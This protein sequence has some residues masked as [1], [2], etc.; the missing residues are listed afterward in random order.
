MNSPLTTQRQREL[1]EQISKL[2]AVRAAGEIEI[3]ARQEARIEKATADYNETR[4]RAMREFEI[5][6][7]KLTTTMRESRE[8]VYVRYESEGFTLGQQERQ[9]RA[10]ATRREATAIENAEYLNQQ[11]QKK[12]LL[13]FEE[14]DKGSKTEYGQFREQIEVRVAEI[15]TLV[16]EARKV[17]ERQGPWPAGEL[18][19]PPASRD[20]PK[21]QLL[22]DA[23]ADYQ[24]ARAC[25]IRLNQA[26]AAR[27]I[28]DGWPFL[29]SIPGALAGF[30][31]AWFLLP[32]SP[33]VIGG[34]V[35]GA[36]AVTGFGV[37]AI[38]KP[39]ARS[40]TLRGVPAFRQQVALAMAKITAAKQSAK[41]ESKLSRAKASVQRDNEIAGATE[42]LETI[43][44]Q[45]AEKREE[46]IAKATTELIQRRRVLEDSCERQLN[47]I[48][49]KSPQQ[50][51]TLE[52]EFRNYYADLYKR[53]MARRAA[54]RAAFENEWNALASQWAEGVAA[55]EKEIGEMQQV[56][57]ATFPKWNDV[58]P[59]HIPLVNEKPRPEGGP[60]DLPAL[61]FGRYEFRLDQLAGGIPTAHGLQMP[62][63]SFAIPAVVSYPEAPSLLFESAEEGRD[64]ASRAIQNVMLRLLTAFPPGK[65]RFTII[66]PVGLGKNFSAFMHLADYDEK[67]V[68]NRI[69]TE[70]SH[71]NQRLADLTEHMENVI[72]K[73]LR[74][75]FASI[76]EYNRSAGEV[77][78][79]FHI[80]VI[81][82]FP[83]NFSDE[84]ARRLVSIA[85]SGARC[86][87]YTLIGVDTKHRVPRNFELSE[88]EA[89]ATTLVWNAELDRFEWKD[90]VLKDL[91]LVCESPP[92]DNKVTEIIRA[93]GKQAK[94]ASRVE[95]PF[96]TVTPTPDNWWTLDSR[97]GIEVPLGRA[98]A[99]KLQYMRLGSGT[100]Q[101]VLI[102]GKTGSGKSTL[103]NAMI[104]NLALYY[105]PNE[106]QFFLI[107][108]KKGVEF[109]AYA[110]HGLPHARVI[111]I[112]SER[113]FGLSVL[114]RLDV[115]L[116]RRGDMFR[117]VGAQDVKGYRAAV[118]DADLPRMML[119]IDE[120]QEFF[121]S[122]DK[123]SHEASLLLD[124]LI[125]QGRAF[126]V[127]VLLGSQTLAGAYSLARATIGQMAVRIALQC[128]ESDAHLILSE[129]N[130]AARLLNRPGEAIY[131]DANGMF[132]GNHPFQIVWL[133]DHQREDYLHRVAEK[134]MAQNIALPPPTVFEGNAAA[135]PAENHLLREAMTSVP[136]ANARL[137]PRM[138][139]GSAVAIKDPPEMIFRRQ[140]GANLL[141][142]GQQEE[143][144][145]GILANAIIALD[146]QTS[147]ESADHANG[148][149]KNGSGDHSLA[150]FTILDGVRPDAAEAGFWQK[151]VSAV[152]PSCKRVS[153]RDA[154]AAVNA[155]A[156]EVDRRLAAGDVSSEP[157]FLI[158]HNLTRFRD[159]K[160]G[161]EMSFGSFD[162]DDAA[163]DAGKRLAT[164][165]REGPALGVHTLSWVD[166]Y[167]NLTRWVERATIR[168]FETR[169]LFQMSNND[170][171]N[172][173]D[174]PAAAKL[175]AHFAL[176][177]SEEQGQAEKFRPYGLPSDAWLEW[178]AEQRSSTGA[179]AGKRAAKKT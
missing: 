139:L 87:V 30:A 81:A 69:W 38:A 34:A 10:E 112:E 29:L 105:S 173:M 89:A 71:I 130:T 120:F 99:K 42:E 121:T 155:I 44:T 20:V 96:E 27:F 161:D 129:D 4:L 92:D 74:N 101:H 110:A 150:R 164:I 170:S 85:T 43:R 175:G 152:G 64:A 145:L 122:D 51:A 127:H 126:G 47:D 135:D 141:V 88:L 133:S 67:L 163:V 79:P 102:A 61:A 108:F 140:S 166:S 162:D 54:D 21:Q 73:Y 179:P 157:L 116:Q 40:Q 5:A 91:P 82:N 83:A 68:T 15:Q 6:H 62:Q 8:R 144:A 53:H 106:L 100:S 66:D 174:S 77:A 103:L 57:E 28:S 35:L 178:V 11:K 19:A 123:I 165:L 65:V 104:T 125:R 46:R 156:D 117:K 147:G 93:V 1:I 94:E 142:V 137:S 143:L 160:R 14:V 7:A 119:I 148:N 95:V 124:R 50:I 151:L 12:A 55:F 16:A 49:E 63:P 45:Q 153:T 25:L 26:P 107:D 138:W 154:A 114:Q 56:C 59:D 17:V 75:E 80:L 70:S 58:D 72:Q 111:A 167:S 32:F 109:K 9:I 48:D 2:V 22:D 149:G 176:R 76:L 118:P 171:S 158:V 134:A 60:V 37:R 86:G 128:S 90:P 172:L 13:Q 131:N 3:N 115:E 84:A 78:E 159:L 132:E 18:K 24:L 136:A 23:A 97:K 33:I 31:V 146:A 36:A 98:G 113:E 168:D 177:F 39:L 169:A 52:N 41:E